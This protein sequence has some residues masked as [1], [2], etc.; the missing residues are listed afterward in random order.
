MHLQR[1]LPP[2]DGIKMVKNLMFLAALSATVL[3]CCGPVP[4]FHR[5]LALA[6]VCHSEISSNQKSENSENFKQKPK[7][8]FLLQLSFH[9]SPP[10]LAV[11]PAGAS[12]FLEKG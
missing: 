6:L 10:F 3:M 5:V 12:G 7:Q 4:D 9:S 2:S 1:G 11:I 8:F